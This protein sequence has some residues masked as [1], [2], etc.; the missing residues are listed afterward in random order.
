M[1]QEAN[2]VFSLEGALL[3]HHVKLAL[4]ADGADHRE[5]IAREFLLQDGRLAHRGVAT[6]HSGQRVEARLVHKQY[7]S[8][9]LYGTFF[10]SG[11]RSSFQRFI[12]SSS[13][14]FARRIGFCR[15]SPSALTS[16]LTCAG[17]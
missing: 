13:R 1:L 5:M 11:Q 16:R 15:E 3:L 17:W 9:L 10:S 7:G 2:H 4:Q 8:T 12:A 14:W 6:N